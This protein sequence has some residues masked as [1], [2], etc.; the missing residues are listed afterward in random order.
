VQAEKTMGGMR[1]EI[2]KATKFF[3]GQKH[4]GEKLAR[5]DRIALENSTHAPKVQSLMSKVQSPKLLN[6]AT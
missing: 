6:R 3:L 4:R 1:L 2:D 5:W